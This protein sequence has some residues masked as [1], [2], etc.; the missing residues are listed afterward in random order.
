M[1]LTIVSYLG[2]ISSFIAFIC[3]FYKL[4]KK[5]D[6][7]NENVK[8]IPELKKDIKKIQE[9]LKEASLATNREVILDE[10]L[11][12]TE[13]IEAGEKY[14]ELGGNGTAKKIID[15]LENEL[16]ERYE[17]KENNYEI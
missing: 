16:A 9:E 14:I 3:A 5:L 1:F 13:R 17:R 10:R 4:I 15:K 11:T 8:E 6:N 12:K 2:A 7:I